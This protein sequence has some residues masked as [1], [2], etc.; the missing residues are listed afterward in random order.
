[1]AI[2]VKHAFVSQVADSTDNTVVQPSNWNAEHTI[3]VA[4]NTVLGRAT[5]GPGAIEEIP[6][7]AI[8]RNI[9]AAAT[10][11]AACTAA[12][13]VAKSGDTMTGPL[14]LPSNGLTVGATQLQVA[15]GNVSCS[16]TLTA[17]DVTITSDKRLK[18]DI[19]QISHALDL[20][21]SLQGVRYTHIDTESRHIGV[22]AQDVQRAVPEVVHEDE[23]GFLSVAYGN[24]TA[25]LIEAVKELA[26]QVEELKRK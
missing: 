6:C 11:G 1:M 12:G 8:G 7:T 25:L 18:R 17:L 16:G 10:L 3:T 20:V 19:V 4:T 15:G 21:R 5:A 13:A 24:L 14:S 26:A 9:L 22:L 2:S 23:D